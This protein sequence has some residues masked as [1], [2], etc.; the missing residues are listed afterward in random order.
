MGAFQ[1]IKK[2][3]E[4][5]ER[6]TYANVLRWP[7]LCKKRSLTITFNLRHLGGRFWHLDIYV[8]KVKEPDGAICFDL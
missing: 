1:Q 2:H 8:F 6:E 3:P 7:A 4:R 5:F